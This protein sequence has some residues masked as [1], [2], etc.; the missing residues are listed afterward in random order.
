MEWTR[1]IAM[2]EWGKTDEGVVSFV[3]IQGQESGG[4][5]VWQK[6]KHLLRFFSIKA[7]PYRQIV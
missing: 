4:R 3:P 2:H 6:L 1:L 7:A 5:G